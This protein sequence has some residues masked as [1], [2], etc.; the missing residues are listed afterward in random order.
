MSLKKAKFGSNRW[1]FGMPLPRGGPPNI[2]MKQET[3]KNCPRD[4]KGTL[5]DPLVIWAAHLTDKQRLELAVPE[6]EDEADLYRAIDANT[7]IAKT[8]AVRSGCT[9]VWIICP[10]H[11][12]K[13]VY[14]KDGNR[15]PTKWDENGKPVEY[16]VTEADPH[17]TVK[18][19]MS[20]DLC[21]I[22]GHVNVVLDERGF[23]TGFMSRSQ[24][25]R[26]GHLTDGDD[27]TME[28]FE[29]IIKGDVIR[30]RARREE[31]DYELFKARTL[32]SGADW[33]IEDE[34]G[35]E[36]YDYESD[37]Y[38]SMNDDRMDCTYDSN[39][40]AAGLSAEFEEYIVRKWSPYQ[41]GSH[42]ISIRNF[43]YSTRRFRGHS[44][45]YY[46]RGYSRNTWDRQG[47]QSP[48]AS[49]Y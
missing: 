11:T 31:E 43:G 41:R 37:E 32:G 18:L 30:E 13:Y 12:S 19:G 20:E 24:R 46:S 8:V 3:L 40:E 16:L 7:D 29:W 25:Y 1:D 5:E 28:L 2:R 23:P 42:P 6:F 38:E 48:R 39:E 17:L 47:R 36:D 26:N 4:W 14:N 27:R 9:V 45:S 34:V 44:S 22:H 10:V 15:V 21:L 49:V 35:D 33:E